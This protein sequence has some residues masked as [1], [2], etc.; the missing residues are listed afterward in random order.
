MFNYVHHFLEYER[1]Y[2]YLINRWLQKPLPK[3]F[4]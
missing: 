4:P 1:L 3:Q 2:E